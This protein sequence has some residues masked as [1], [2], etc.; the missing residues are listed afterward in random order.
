[1]IGTFSILSSIVE[2]LDHTKRYLYNWKRFHEYWLKDYR[3][4]I[5]VTLYEDLAEDIQSFTE[6][7]SYF[8]YF[9]EGNMKR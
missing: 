1:M 8:G 5:K 4:P 7:T 9:V 2:F 3:G 6:I